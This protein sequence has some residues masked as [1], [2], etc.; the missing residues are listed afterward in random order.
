MKLI[1]EILYWDRNPDFSAKKELA[2]IV[3]GCPIYTLFTYFQVL[4]NGEIY[5]TNNG[6]LKGKLQFW[7]N[8]DD[9][10]VVKSGTILKHFDTKFTLMALMEEVPGS[11]GTEFF[12]VS[13]DGLNLIMKVS[14]RTVTA[15]IKIVFQMGYQKEEGVD[16][17]EKTKYKSL[18]THLIIEERESMLDMLDIPM[19]LSF[20]FHETAEEVIKKK[21]NR[22]VFDMMYPELTARIAGNELHFRHVSVQI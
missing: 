15:D 21:T 2:F 11:M 5:G 3:N 12:A 4:D 20:C 10:F 6:L 17:T 14:N 22:L 19:D 8:I 7:K 16:D 13:P 18:H 1:N 9:G